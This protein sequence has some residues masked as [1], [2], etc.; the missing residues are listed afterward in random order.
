MA[1]A[2]EA[3]GE[4]EVLV[5]GRCGTKV[6]VFEAGDGEAEV[7]ELVVGGI[8]AREDGVVVVNPMLGIVVDVERCRPGTA[9]AH[10][11]VQHEK[12]DGGIRF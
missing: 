5:D 8:E 12:L 6:E 7:D 11:V 10:L 2:G 9:D 3:G 4:V 1:L